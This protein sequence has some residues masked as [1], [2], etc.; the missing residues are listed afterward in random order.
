[1]FLY[2]KTATRS[3]TTAN[4]H[5]APLCA[6]RVGHHR[7]P[8]QDGCLFNATPQNKNAA[9]SNGT[10]R[11]RINRHNTSDVR[12]EGGVMPCALGVAGSWRRSA[13][14]ARRRTGVV[15]LFVR[16]VHAP[17]L[18]AWLSPRPRFSSRV[19]LMRLF[20]VR[21]PAACAVYMAERPRGMTPD[22]ASGRR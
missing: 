18:S 5:F 12:C 19:S 15:L 17:P 9:P 16:R 11:T 13:A 14:G 21:R 10:S 6:K 22:A 2:G 7:T 20:F 8:H 1:M 3:V 4:L